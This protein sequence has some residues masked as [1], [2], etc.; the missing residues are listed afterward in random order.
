MIRVGILTVSD[1]SARGERA[2]LSG[3]ALEMAI[4][5]GPP[6]LGWLCGMSSPMSASSSRP[7]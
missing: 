7:A 6:R 3:P 4:A 1:R 2:D 5:E